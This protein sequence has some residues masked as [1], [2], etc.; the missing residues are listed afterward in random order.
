M[1]SC[2]LGNGFFIFLI[3][4]RRFPMYS[5]RVVGCCIGLSMVP[6]G[7]G[8]FQSA[9]QT[10]PKDPSPTSLITVK[11]LGPSRIRLAAVVGM[12]FSD[13]GGG[14]RWEL[15]PG[16][17]GCALVW[18]ERLECMAM[19]GLYIS[20]TEGSLEP[21]TTWVMFTDGRTGSTCL[22]IRMSAVGIDSWRGGSCRPDD[23]HARCS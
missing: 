18:W 9:K 14:R 23:E 11:S 13:G 12:P 8:L 6:L 1:H 19:A 3:A 17:S 7:S 20:D 2:Q 16:A 10:V 15:G 21:E 4:T 5:G 22:S